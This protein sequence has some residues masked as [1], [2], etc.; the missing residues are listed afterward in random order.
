MARTVERFVGKDLAVSY[1]TLA[2]LP[3]NDQIE[4]VA[5]KVKNFKK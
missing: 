1:E 3:T 2:A 4:Y 5:N